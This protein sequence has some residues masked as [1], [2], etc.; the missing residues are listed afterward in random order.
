MNTLHA[1]VAMKAK[2][3]IKWKIA[4]RLTSQVQFSKLKSKIQNLQ[5]A[6]KKDSFMTS[7]TAVNFALPQA[8]AMSGHVLFQAKVSHSNLILELIILHSAV[9]LIQ[10][11]PNGRS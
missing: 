5:Q 2:M 9:V 11:V 8:T 6:S 4:F 3:G 7:G 10:C 1:R